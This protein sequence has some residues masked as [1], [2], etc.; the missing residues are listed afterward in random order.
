VRCWFK[1]QTLRRYLYR[2]QKK[3]GIKAGFKKGC[4][5]SILFY[6]F[7]PMFVAF[8]TR[9]LNHLFG[10][11]DLASILVK[12]GAPDRQ[13]R[14]GSNDRYV[15]GAVL[16][17]HGLSPHQ[18]VRFKVNPLDDRAVTFLQRIQTAAQVQQK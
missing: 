14:G 12:D 10:D 16:Q 18:V 11:Q 2:R 7:D 3:P 15:I 9:D 5:A 17:A 4:A 8:L 13:G 6:G 1:S